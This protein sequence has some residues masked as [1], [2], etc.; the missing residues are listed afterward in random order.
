MLKSVSK[1]P[2][3]GVLA[4]ATVLTLVAVPVVEASAAANSNNGY[5]LTNKTSVT[6][7]ASA[8]RY[9]ITGVKKGTKVTVLVTNGVYVGKTKTA[10]TNGA[11]KIT[12]TGTGKTLK[13]YVKVPTTYT[14]TKANVKVT[15]AKTSSK[16]KTVIKD[17]FTVA[18]SSVEVTG[19]TLSTTKPPDAVHDCE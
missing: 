9:N 5:N 2:L 12:L 1:K 8:V 3:S 19:V 17:S 15:V 6:A 11:R 4:P 14:K 16:K 18:Q 7:G 13:F 10:T